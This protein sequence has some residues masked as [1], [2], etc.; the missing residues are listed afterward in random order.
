MSCL[1]LVSL[2]ASQSS[3]IP[4]RREPSSC[5]PAIQ[6]TEQALRTKLLQ[7]RVLGTGSA[8]KRT[9][10]AQWN[11]QVTGNTTARKMKQRKSLPGKDVASSPMEILKKQVGGNPYQYSYIAKCT[12]YAAM[13]SP[14]RATHS[15]RTVS[16]RQERQTAAVASAWGASPVSQFLQTLTEHLNF[17]DILASLKELKHLWSYSFG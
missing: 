1:V 2:L 17:L 14:P 15:S 4:E 6:V 11:I 8:L 16:C 10:A 5:T 7:E 13:I 9:A 3:N 12:M